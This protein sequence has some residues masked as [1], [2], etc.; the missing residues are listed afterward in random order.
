VNAPHKPASST[1]PDVRDGLTELERIILLELRNLAA[2]CGPRGVSSAM[3]YGRVCARLP[4]GT[5]VFEATLRRLV[6]R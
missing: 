5:R 3:L 1:L 2:V 6:G 4:V